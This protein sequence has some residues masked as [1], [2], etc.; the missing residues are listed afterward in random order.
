[1]VVAAQE[2]E[3]TAGD[4]ARAEMGTPMTRLHHRRQFRDSEFWVCFSMGGD[5][6]SS[7]IRSSPSRYGG[8]IQ[9]H[10]HNHQLAYVSSDTKILT[11]DRNI[12][13]SS[14]CNTS[15]NTDRS[16]PTTPVTAS[17]QIGSPD[18]SSSTAQV[19]ASQTN[20]DFLGITT[21]ENW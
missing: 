14:L 11:V 3:E 16:S 17:V 5:P 10:P 19:T 20:L 6:E 15:N 21:P 8:K 1:M 9:P 2:Q 7:P 12:K 18:G 4:G 13:L